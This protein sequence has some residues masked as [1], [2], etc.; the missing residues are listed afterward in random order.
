[1]PMIEWWSTGYVLVLPSTSRRQ[2]GSSKPGYFDF[3]YFVW[4]PLQG[5]KNRTWNLLVMRPWKLRNLDR[6]IFV[7]TRPKTLCSFPITH[8]PVLI[9][10]RIVRSGT[11]ECARNKPWMLAKCCYAVSN[12][13]T[14]RPSFQVLELINFEFDF[15]FLCVVS[16]KKRRIEVSKFGTPKF[17]LWSR[18][19]V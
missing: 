9:G 13:K 14:L 2:L 17:P 16:N 10:Y 1:M 5:N 18:W 6:N 7:W 15:C 4:T 12:Q 11:E 3:H 19:W 8:G